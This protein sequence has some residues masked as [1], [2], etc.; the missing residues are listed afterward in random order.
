LVISYVKNHNL[1]LEVP[2]TYGSGMRT[3]IPDFIV[4]T[5]DGNEDLLNLIKSGN[6][7]HIYIIGATIKGTFFLKTGITGIF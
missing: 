6:Y 5:D 7:Y 1:G 3:Y 4:Q 2:Y